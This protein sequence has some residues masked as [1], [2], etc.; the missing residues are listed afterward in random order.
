[1][2]SELH[3]TIFTAKQERHK[4]LFLNYRNLNIFPVELLKDEGLQFLERLYMKR[5]SLT[6]LPENLAQKLPNLIELT[7]VSFVAYC[8]S[9]QCLQ[10]FDLQS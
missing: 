1:M 8:C 5:N 4:N 10:M 2:A 6:T 9:S 7:T 3:E